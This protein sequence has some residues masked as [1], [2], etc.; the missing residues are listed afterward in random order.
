MPDPATLT[1][2]NV[3]RHWHGIK[4]VEVHPNNRDGWHR[5]HL[6]CGMT[7]DLHAK[8]FKDPIRFQVAQSV[9]C[10]ACFLAQP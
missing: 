3:D 9:T 2:A 4:E 6:K 7:I 8:G 1:A 5:V 10:T